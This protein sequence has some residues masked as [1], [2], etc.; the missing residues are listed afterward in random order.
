LYTFLSGINR[1]KITPA[2]SAIKNVLALEVII[3]SNGVLAQTMALIKPVTMVAT[4]PA[5]FIQIN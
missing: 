2:K 1:L 4:I 3:S 5:R